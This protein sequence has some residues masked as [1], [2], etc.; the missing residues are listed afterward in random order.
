MREFGLYLKSKGYEIY[1]VGLKHENY[2]GVGKDCYG[3]ELHDSA[4][5]MSDTDLYIGLDNGLMHLAEALRIPI[6]CIFGCTCPLYLVHDWEQARVLWKNSR[7]VP[8]AACYN[9]RRIPHRMAICNKDKFYCLD[10]SVDELIYAFENSLYNNPPKVEEDM[11]E[12]L[13]E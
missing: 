12:P 10:W 3:L 9:R 4:K 13:F 1:E 7:E 6:F 5:V 2:L 8:C 11:F